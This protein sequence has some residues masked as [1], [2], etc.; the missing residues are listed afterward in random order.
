MFWITRKKGGGWTVWFPSGEMT[1]IAA[2]PA[3]LRKLLES[4]DFSDAVV[5]R[6]FPQAHR[7]DPEA[8]AEYVQLLRD[9]LLRRKLET[10]DIFERTLRVRRGKKLLGGVALVEVDLAEED[11][12]AWLGVHHDL[13]LL[14]GTRL[15]ITEEVWEKGVNPKDPH[16]RELEMLHRLAFLEEVI[17]EALRESEELE[18]R[19]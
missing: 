3:E 10:I 5:R 18:D 11:L 12:S 14:I 8:E 17:I 4:P 9:D 15:D 16:A 2:L 1:D 7:D 6:L 13:R 19:E